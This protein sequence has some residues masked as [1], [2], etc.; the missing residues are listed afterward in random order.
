[1]SVRTYAVIE[2]ESV[3]AEGN[4]DDP[5]IERESSD[6]GKRLYAALHTQYNMVVVH[7]QP[8]DKAKHWLMSHGF[9]GWVIMKR[10]LAPEVHTDLRRTNGALGLWV[11]G[12]PATGRH[13]LREGLAVL[14]FSQPGYKRK[15]WRPDH[16]RILK[17]W[18]VIEEEVTEQMVMRTKDLRLDQ[19][20]EGRFE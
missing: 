20:H 4:P 2:V 3:L 15:E 12:D 19:E 10:G 7:D 13:L 18:D 1:M 14:L 17:P 9:G 8:E 16:D 6:D 5:F 11:T